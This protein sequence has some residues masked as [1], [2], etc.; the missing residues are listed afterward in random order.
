MK[1]RLVSVTRSLTKVHF[2]CGYPELNRYLR[3]YA[4]KND[5]LSIGKSF[6]ALNPEGDVTGYM[7]I[8]TAQITISSLPDEVRRGLPAYPVPAFRIGKLAVDKRFQH[9]GV[10]SWLL[11]KA[12]EKAVEV[13]R[14]V[15]LYTVVVDA[16]DERAKEFYLKYGFIPFMEHPLSLFLPLSTIKR[17]M[18]EAGGS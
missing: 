12:L 15:G 5:K 18:T 17:A 13:S 8:S 2:D 6:I 11:G 1:L 7:T 9:V 10:G 16:I 14:H 3:L 4:L